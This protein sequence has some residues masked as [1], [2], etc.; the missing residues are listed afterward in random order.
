MPQRTLLQPPQDHYP[1]H[2]IHNDIKTIS[3]NNDQRT[4]N[5]DGHYSD[6]VFYQGHQFS[7]QQDFHYTNIPMLPVIVKYKGTFQM[8]LGFQIK[9]MQDVNQTLNG[10][11]P[12]VFLKWNFEDNGDFYQ[13]LGLSLGTSEEWTQYSSKGFIQNKIYRIV[14]HFPYTSYYELGGFYSIFMKEFP[15]TFPNISQPN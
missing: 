4:I 10:D 12:K 2:T 6:Q 7:A 13:K 9:W 11:E 14:S 15:I 1:V 3:Q 8:G 5:F